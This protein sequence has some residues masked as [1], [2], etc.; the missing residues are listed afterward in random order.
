[1]VGPLPVPLRVA[2]A[3]LHSRLVE[4]GSFVWNLVGQQ[5]KDQ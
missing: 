4:V 2:R 3:L 1:M 5:G